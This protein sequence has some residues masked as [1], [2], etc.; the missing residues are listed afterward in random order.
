MRKP[1]INFT[2]VGQVG[3]SNQVPQNRARSPA[4]NSGEV[5][6]AVSRSPARFQAAPRQTKVRWRNRMKQNKIAKL[7]GTL[8]VA[9]KRE[10]L[11]WQQRMI[12][13]QEAQE[14]YT[15]AKSAWLQKATGEQLALKEK[16]DHAL[17]KIRENYNYKVAKIQADGRKAAQKLREAGL[18]NTNIRNL[19]TPP[20]RR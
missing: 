17:A 10:G 4:E 11:A 14:S 6:Q 13:E 20:L 2:K 7:S 5:T 12:A 15:R 18:S 16:R 1:L 9:R 3:T 19:E 8:V